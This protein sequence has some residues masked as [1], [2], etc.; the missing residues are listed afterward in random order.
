MLMD[1][2]SK[3]WTPVVAAMWTVAVPICRFFKSLLSVAA[4]GNRAN[5]LPAVAVAEGN[6]E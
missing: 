2:I 5:H 1:G 6:D 3:D 4:A